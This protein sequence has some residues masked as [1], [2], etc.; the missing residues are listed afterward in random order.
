[1]E[2]FI[3][4]NHMF[5]LLIIKKFAVFMVMPRQS[6]KIFLSNDPNNTNEL[7]DSPGANIDDASHVE[8]D[9]FQPDIFDPRY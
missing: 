2:K 9:S 3:I 7:D 1:M 4:K 8:D 5:L 6:L